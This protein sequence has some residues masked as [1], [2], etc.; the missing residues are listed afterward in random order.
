MEEENELNPTTLPYFKNDK[1]VLLM[2]ITITFVPTKI[3]KYNV[4]MFQHNSNI[5]ILCLR[6][7]ARPFSGASH[8]GSTHTEDLHVRWS[9][10]IWETRTIAVSDSYPTIVHY[11]AEARVRCVVE[12]A[13]LGETF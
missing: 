12:I 7:D 13:Q 10:N 6:T 3:F 4:S 8:G 1:S 5:D 2:N 9:E 11:K